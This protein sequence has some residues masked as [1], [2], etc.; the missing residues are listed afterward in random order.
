MFADLAAFLVALSAYTKIKADPE[1]GHAKGAKALL[2]RFQGT[3]SQGF[4]E[5]LLP[6]TSASYLARFKTRINFAGRN[7]RGFDFALEQAEVA[8]EVFT[9][10][11]SHTDKLKETFSESRATMVATK[12]G[13]ASS[14]ED[15]MQ[16]LNTLATAPSASSLTATRNWIREAA[17]IVGAAP[18]DIETTLADADEAVSL[19][20]DLKKIESVID[21][22]DPSSVQAV[23]LQ[24]TRGSILSRIQNVAD[25]S[26]APSVVM[27]A[28][29]QAASGPRQYA[30]KT[31]AER[32]L[33][34]DKETAMMI[35]G[36][37]IIAAGAGSGKTLTLASK[38]VYHIRELGLSPE[39]VLA[40]SF[41]RKSA[42][43]LLKRINDYG[44]EIPPRSTGFGTTHSI[45]AKLMRSYGAPSRDSLKPYEATD[46]FSLAMKQVQMGPF[47]IPVPAPTSIFAGSVPS[48]SDASI[49]SPSDASIPSFSD[50]LKAA[51]DARSRLGSPFLRSFIESYFNPSDKWYGLTKSKTKNFTDPSGLTDKQKDI[52]QQVFD[53][54][55]GRFNVYGTGRMAG[56]KF[57]QSLAQKYQSATSPARQWFNIG[58]PLVSEK[59]DPIPMGD[60]G[61]YV[62]KMKGR[63]VSPTEAWAFAG[64][65]AE[66]QASA[67]VY[68][69]YEYLK[70]PNGEPS[71]AGKGDFDDVLLDVSK[72]MLSNPNTLRAV[73]SRFKVVLVDEAQ[74]LNR[75]QHLM[76]GLI[77]GFVDPKK[78]PL[79]ASAKKMVELA[80]DDDSMTADTYC[81]IGDDKQC[82][83]ANSMVETQKGPRRVKD[84]APGDEVLAFRNGKVLLQTVR[85]VVPSSWAWGY[86]VTMESGQTLAMSPNHKLWAS[87]PQ[88]EEG[89]IAVYLMYRKDM[90]F[91]VGITNKGKVGSE[92]DYLNSY[93]GRVFLEKAERLWIL[94]ICSSREEALL[95]ET[96]ISLTYGI[97]T[98]VFNGEHRDLNQERIS[99]IFQ[100]HGSKGAR[101][102][103]ERNL[104]FDLPHWMSQSYTKHGRER[105]TVQFLAHST[106]GSQVT[107]EWEGGKFDKVLDGVEFSLSGDRRRLRRWFGNYREGLAHA[108]DVARRTGANLS[109]RM[110]TPE[111]VLRETTASG[112]FIGM[113]LP[114]LDRENEAITLDRISSIERVDGCFIDLDVLDASNFFANGILTSN[115]IYEFRGADP[116]AFIDMSDLVEGGAGFKTEVLKTNYRSGELIVQAANRL[117]AYNSKQIPMTCDANPK[118]TDK[119][120]VTTIPFAPQDPNDMTAPAEWMASQ[121]EE[122]VDI[123]QTGDKGYDSFGVGLRT[124]AEA[125]IYGL[126]LLKKGIPFRSKAN[127]FKDRNTK[128][129]LAW[130]TIVDEGAD[131]NVE[132]LNAAILAARAAPTSMLGQTFEQR[133]TEQATGNYLKWLQA[134]YESVY[135]YRA[136]NTA[137][138]EAFVKNLEYAVSLK[139]GN[140]EEILAALLKMQGAS[141]QSVTEALIDAVREDAD[142]MAELRGV[143]LDGKV[144]DDAVTNRAF[145]PIDPLVGLLGARADLTESMKF[146]RTLQSA[147]EKLSAEDDPEAKGF[148]APAVTLG[149]IHSWKGLEVE[150]MFVPFVG[151]KFPRAESEED[152]AAERRLA[153]VAMT[154]AQNQL[155]IMDIPTVR[156]TKQGPVVRRSQFVG[157]ACAPRQSPEGALKM[158]SADRIATPEGWSPLSDD[159]ID[160]Y[161]RGEDPFATGTEAMDDAWGEVLFGGEM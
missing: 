36:K 11:R 29:V 63:A 66:R 138:V 81:F 17:E 90:G 135:G 92:D 76:F 24:E 132:R 145:A 73:Q 68:G 59:G 46:L 74:D 123:G 150:T 121:I 9:V 70:G 91:R 133:L 157:E 124:N 3:A 32:R 64:S 13:L 30:T 137:N 98:T 16:I 112:L 8:Q 97:P 154:R 58:N 86:K 22:L 142:A 104:S 6:A 20:A 48:P 71:M 82:V 115:S 7:T 53:K 56:V 101:L 85:H 69:A 100:K 143:S 84:L 77:S 94:D 4:R 26:P 55:G 144:S 148:A 95:T 65:D 75:A 134:N 37:G 42:A 106:S 156:E 50:A 96:D 126:E 31:G 40:T 159:A 15:P 120:G 131:G 153:Y 158:G 39:S 49:P 102:L 117:I 25:E 28:A 130:L 105:H 122:M 78:V 10:L 118:R 141:G 18:S 41:S 12:V 43:E 110:A 140:G 155:F 61:Q 111:G 136:R 51:F 89:Q 161:L 14:A 33:N 151:G 114:V 60:F 19:G 149:T 79:V 129:L 67:A 54:T 44:G 45:A 62:T 21:K 107:M 5:V 52:L 113:S 23:E 93:G 125:Y 38:V 88:T 83:E 87:E 152:L 35:R 119:G 80:K 1:D 109:Y 99:A 146:V 72:M 139:G 2:T 116:A 47:G 57:D 27:A 108:E 34:P 128:A 127:F 103:E 160:A 147:S